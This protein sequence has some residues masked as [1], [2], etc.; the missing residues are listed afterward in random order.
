[1]ARAKNKLTA[2]EVKTA[3]PGKLQDG[4]GLILDKGESGG[5]WIF[6]YSIAGRRRDMGLGTYPSVG[7]AAARAERDKWAAVLHGGIDPISERERRIE[8]EKAELTRDDPTLTRLVEMVFEAKKATLRGEGT[9]GRWMSPLEKHVLPKLG[10]RIASKIHQTDIRDALAPIWRT[11]HE[12]AQKAISRLGITFQRG[13]LAGYSV[14]PFT[15]EAAKHLLG[16]VHHE[17]TPIEATPWQDIP[18]LFQRLGEN[19]TTAHLCLQFIM[20]TVVRGDAARGARLDEIEGA[21]W[22]VPAQRVKGTIKQAADFRVPITDAA[23]DVIERCAPGA[24]DGLL[25]PAKKHNGQFGAIS[26]N[27]LEKALNVL[28][29]AGRPHGFRTSFRTWV[30]DTQA[31]TFDVAE[32]ALGHTIGGK[33]ERSYARSDLLDQRRVLMTKWAAFVTGETAKVV[34]LRG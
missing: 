19:P 16:E 34:R 31:A 7:L 13:R 28:G 12:T 33:V 20:L 27:A 2:M 25:F 9:R 17:P 1:M 21:V 26:A 30:Q 32:T 4:G 8:A 5:K 24:V 29:E 11:K 6:R 18:A 14:D 3:A 15:V 23:R 10:T 22:T